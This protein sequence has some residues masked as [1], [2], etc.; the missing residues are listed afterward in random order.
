LPLDRIIHNWLT[1]LCITLKSVVAT[2]SKKKKSK[3]RKRQV[4]CQPPECPQGFNQLHHTV[5][6]N[7]AAEL[8]KQ[9]PA[10]SAPAKNQAK[11]LYQDKQDG[12]QGEC[13]K[14][15]GGTRQ[16]HGIVFYKEPESLP[17]LFCRI[18]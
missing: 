4:T 2:K 13:S 1:E 10:Y 14:E 11:Q 9:L 12:W 3:N 6:S 5:F 17:E 16:P 18:Q 15:C 8:R 7:N